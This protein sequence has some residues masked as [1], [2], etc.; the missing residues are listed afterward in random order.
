MYFE[1]ETRDEKNL[2]TEIFKDKIFNYSRNY[3]KAVTPSF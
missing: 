1:C 3:S 2:I